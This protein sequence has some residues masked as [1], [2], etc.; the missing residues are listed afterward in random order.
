MLEHLAT[1]ITPWIYIIAKR[2]GSGDCSL[3]M[4]GNSTSEGWLI[5]SNF[6]ED[7]ESPIQ[8][9][10]RIE[11]SRSD[12]NIIMENK[13]KNYSQWFPAWM[14]DVSDALSW[15]D[16]RSDNKQIN[17]FCSF[18][19]SQIPAHFEIVPLPR[20]I[21]FWPILLLQRLPIK[22]QLLEQHTRTKPGRGQGGKTT[23]DQLEFLRMNSST[24]LPEV[25]ESE[26]W[27]PL[28]WLSLKGDFQDHLMGTN[29][30][31][32]SSFGDC[33]TLNSPFHEQVKGIA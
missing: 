33:S 23:A 26:S 17:I 21:S 30:W 31:K 14:N 1:V 2:L 10:V 8:A 19:P 25:N 27:E 13:I 29:D 22:E 16:D 24:T 32:T 4:R 20:E 12:T 6:K 5:K 11:V 7:G 9:T 3:S 15:D 18:T 28:P